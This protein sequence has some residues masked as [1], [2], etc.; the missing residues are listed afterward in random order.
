QR[1]PLPHHLPV[2]VAAVAVDRAHGAPV[3]VGVHDADLHDL[4]EDLDRLRGRC[5]E[6]GFQLTR[7][8]S[9][10]GYISIYLIFLIKFS[11]LGECEISG[12]DHSMPAER[13]RERYRLAR[14]FA[15]AAL[16]LLA[17]QGCDGGAAGP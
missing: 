1:V 6:H 11:R 15:A 5:D 17:G 12:D 10:R 4:A 13:A 7:R 14:L 3:A 9:P 8:D 2:D 16:W